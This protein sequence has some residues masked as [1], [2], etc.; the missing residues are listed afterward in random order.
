MEIQNVSEVPDVTPPTFTQ[1]YEH[2]TAV[3]PQKNLRAMNLNGIDVTFLVVSA[4]DFK[5]Y[6][7]TFSLTT[8]THIQYYYIYNRGS[9]STPVVTLGAFFN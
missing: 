1:Y 6:I 4:L 8:S 2:D 3:I 7:G 9:L 5:M